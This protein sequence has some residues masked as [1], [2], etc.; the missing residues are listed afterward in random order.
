[1]SH[2]IEGVVAG[3]AVAIVVLIIFVRWANSH[4]GPKLW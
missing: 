4:I 1:M 2:F 3:G